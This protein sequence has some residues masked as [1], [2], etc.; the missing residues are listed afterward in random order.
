MTQ[1]NGGLRDQ[2]A[3]HG[4]EHVLRFWDGLDAVGQQRLRSQLERLDLPRLAEHYEAALALGRVRPVGFEPAPVVALPEHGGDAE[5]RR[6]AREAGEQ[7]LAEGQVASLVVAGG[8]GTRLGFGGPKGGYP[9]G[10]V[11]GRTLFGLQAQKLRGVARRHGRPLPWLVMTSPGNDAETRHLFRA[12]DWFGLD[13]AQ[14]HF[15]TQA[16]VPCFDFEGRL[17]LAAPD[18]LAASPDGHGG[19]LPALAA[20]G[21]LQKLREAGAS[22]LSYYQVD[23]PLAPVADPQLLGFLAEPGVEIA[24]KVV[25]KRAPDERVG[26]MAFADGRTRVIEYTEIQEPQRSE[27][28]EDG[29][30]RFWAGGISIHAFDLAFLDRIAL[31]ADRLLPYHASA[32][33]IPTV[34]DAGHP[35]APAEPNGLKLERFVFDAMPEASE[36]ALVEIRRDEEY[37][38]VKNLEG[39]ESPETA[40]IALDRCVR[41]WLRE[42]G[43]TAPETGLL[44]VDHA[45][46]DGPEDARALGT[47]DLAL[48]PEIHTCGSAADDPTRMDSGGTR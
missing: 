10:P 11:S 41:G 33:K 19:V 30:L 39:G 7:M 35:I 32:K 42:A 20:A 28:G 25:R 46:I 1:A 5:R 31:D 8:Q 3:A 16:T 14:V 17:M 21:L 13:P 27:R 44:E 34:D 48:R 23:N 2:L 12:E 6:R 38:P 15:F 26:T 9:L 45:W 22:A 40:R 43:V 24:S 47:T 37:A 29:E 36:C 4:Q 18:R